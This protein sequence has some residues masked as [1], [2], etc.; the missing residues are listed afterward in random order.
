[1]G[2]GMWVCGCVCVLVCVGVCGCVW[3]CGDVF[4]GV[5]CKIF[6]IKSMILIGKCTAMKPQRRLLGIRNCTCDHK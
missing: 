5:K 2:A 4:V 1:M 3:V 6:E